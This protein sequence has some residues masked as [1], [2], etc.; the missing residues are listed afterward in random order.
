MSSVQARPFRGNTV[1][2]ASIKP[3]RQGAA[4]AQA[5]FPQRQDHVRAGAESAVAGC[6]W[7]AVFSG[8]TWGD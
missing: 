8:A 7:L 3:P 2:A 5:A 1:G 4:A 6:H